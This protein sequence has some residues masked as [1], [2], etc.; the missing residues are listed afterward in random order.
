MLTGR[1]QYQAPAFHEPDAHP[2]L[3]DV[4]MEAGGGPLVGGVSE[5]FQLLQVDVGCEHWEQEALPTG[6]AAWCSVS[7]TSCQVTGFDPRGVR[8]CLKGNQGLRPPLE[9][10]RGSLGAP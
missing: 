9:S 3:S 1:P 4:G 8:P 5:S 10:R 7:G 6:G 2:R